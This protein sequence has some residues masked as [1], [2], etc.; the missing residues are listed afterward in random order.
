MSDNLSYVE[1]ILVDKLYSINNNLCLL[2]EILSTN[3]EINVSHTLADIER[4]LEKN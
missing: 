1:N 4:L 2:I 3:N